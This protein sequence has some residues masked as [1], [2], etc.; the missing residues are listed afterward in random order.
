MPRP[1]SETEKKTRTLPLS[2]VGSGYASTATNP[3]VVN[4]KALPI[5]FMSTYRPEDFDETPI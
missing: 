2:L 5:R 4:L 1:E 3:L